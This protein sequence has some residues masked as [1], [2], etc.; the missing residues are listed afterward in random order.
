M[1]LCVEDRRRLWHKPGRPRPAPR[2]EPAA[3]LRAAPRPTP[4]ASSRRWR[5]WTATSTTALGASPPTLRPPSRR[6]RA[7]CGG[8]HGCGGGAC[9][10]P[11][12]PAPDRC[13]LVRQPPPG[14]HRPGGARPPR[15]ARRRS[16]CSRCA[17]PPPT[18]PTRAST[19][20]Y[21]TRGFASAAPHAHPSPRPPAPARC[22]LACGVCGGAALPEGG[23]CKFMCKDG[24]TVS[25]P[26]KCEGGHVNEGGEATCDPNPCVFPSIKNRSLRCIR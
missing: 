15:A 12:R 1:D 14:L 2:T 6:R 5:I 21:P 9:A 7:P 17:P 23:S 3:G 10:A 26:T 22:P 19:P 13:R 25:E 16:G 8:R 11:S 20:L 18:H 4:C 24:Y